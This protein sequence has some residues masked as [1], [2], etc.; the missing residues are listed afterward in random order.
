MHP[1]SGKVALRPQ[2]R[3]SSNLLNINNLDEKQLYEREAHQK[4]RGETLLNS[5]KE[6][7]IFE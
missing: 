3:S 5:P 1:R 6:K 4:S 2:N 7:V